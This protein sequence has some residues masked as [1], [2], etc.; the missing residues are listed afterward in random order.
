MTAFWHLTTL[1]CIP[2]SNPKARL[3]E[4]KI[5]R[6]A[7]NDAA[8]RAEMHAQGNARARWTDEVSRVPSE[9]AN[10]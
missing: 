9:N 6:Q 10:C 2:I 4:Q 5:F 1:S 3:Q 7:A 8:V